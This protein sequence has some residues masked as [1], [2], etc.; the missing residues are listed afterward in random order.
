MRRRAIA[1]LWALGCEPSPRTAEPAPLAAIPSD[2]VAATADDTRRAAAGPAAPA[3]APAPRDALVL[4]TEPDVLDALT[5]SGLSLAQV[6]FARE[7]GD[8]AALAKDAHYRSIVDALAGD[9]AALAADDPRAGV[10]LRHTHRLF[11]LGWLTSEHA[12]FELVGVVN[13]V[14]RR[15]FDPRHCGETR[16]IYRLAH[17]AVQVREEVRS[18][19]PMT[20]NVVLWQ[21][22]DG[23][24]CRDVA[25]RW[26]V[27]ERST[28][29]QLATHL[30]GD[31]GPLAPARR[32]LDALAAIEIDVQTSRWPGTIRPDL[33]GHASYMLRVFHRAERKMIAAPLENTPDVAKLRGSKAA[34]ERLLAWLREPATLDA[35]DRGIAVM[36]ES[37]AARSSSSFTPR[38]LAR[39]GNRPFSQL[40]RASDVAE[41]PLAEHASIRTPA[42]LLRRLD[43]LTCA[44]CHESRSIAGFHLLGDDAD[45]PDRV[46]ALAVGS[47]P[48]LLGDL[49]R[50]EAYLRALAAGE[51][52]DESRPLP[53][54]DPMA[55]GH[56]AHCGLGDP[57]FAALRCA[58]GLVCTAVDDP[59]LGTCLGATAQAGDPCQLGTMST[60]PDPLRDRMRYPKDGARTCE[61]DGVCNGNAVGFPAGSCARTCT[62]LGDD[63]ACG[64]IP[65][66][67]PFNDC[68]ASGRGFATCM[69]KTANPA[70]MRACDRERA[71]RDDYICARVDGHGVCMPPYFLYQLRV[72]GHPP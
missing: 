44:G 50:R 35:I 39:L 7:A 33:G 38:G 14:D 37:L 66:L 15:P 47:S 51:S 23:H 62:A 6:G 57:G 64:A 32:G 55:G 53:D 4:V 58:S 8:N 41:L 1:L 68:L 46:D 10:G 19:L 71:C 28:P 30:V 70:A 9:L 21:R 67:R 72:D 2:A 27:P 65:Q 43:A 17:R 18:R 16:L 42:A 12:W 49:P 56:G 22:D 13:R 5:R 20:V 48:H 60:Q 45:D 11:D 3:P 59:E 24:G 36:P 40:L 61:Q 69:R 34:R 31:D 26:L 29:A 52:V 63:E 25:T 54:H